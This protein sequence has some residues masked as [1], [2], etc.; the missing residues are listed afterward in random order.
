MNFIYNMM[1]NIYKYSYK[2]LFPIFKT[3][4]KF[5]SFI[6]GHVFKKLHLLIYSLYIFAKSE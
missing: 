2:Y 4:Y 5:Y 1:K 3:V 6:V